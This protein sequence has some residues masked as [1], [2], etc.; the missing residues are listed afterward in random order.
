MAYIGDDIN[1]YELLSEVGF[2]ACP[3]NA[4]RK[5]KKIPNILHLEK[6]GGEGVFR[7]FVEEILME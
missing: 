4:T 7:E 1:C 3:A 6:K 2:A 5:I